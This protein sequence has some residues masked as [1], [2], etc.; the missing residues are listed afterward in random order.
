MEMGGR[1]LSECGDQRFGAAETIERG[2]SDA[3]GI[4]GALAAGIETAK[5]RLP[6]FAAQD[7]NWAGAAG[8]R[9]CEYGILR[10][11][12]AEL[13]VERGNGLLEHSGNLR[14]KYGME[15]AKRN[16]GAVGRANRTERRAGAAGEEVTDELRGGAIVGAA[17]VERGLL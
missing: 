12:A 6:H 16:A 2:G 4:A 8:F 15:V 7:A 5:R 17:G 13:A 10:C 9:R 3:A 11:K 1:C 14:R